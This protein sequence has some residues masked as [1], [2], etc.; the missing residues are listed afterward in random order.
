MRGRRQRITKVSYLCVYNKPY[1]KQISQ[2]VIGMFSLTGTTQSIWDMSE[3][4]SS[5]SIKDQLEQSSIWEI[6]RE[7]RHTI[8]SQDK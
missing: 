3:N 5:S 2:C 1:L 6:R 8:N 7:S 4:I